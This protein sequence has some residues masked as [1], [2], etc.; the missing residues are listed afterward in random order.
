MQTFKE[1]LAEGVDGVP[2]RQ[3]TIQLGMKAAEELRKKGLS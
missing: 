2:R 3:S 1:F